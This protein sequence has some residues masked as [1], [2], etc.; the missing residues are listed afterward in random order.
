MSINSGMDK[1]VVIYIHIHICVCVCVCVC[2]CN[3]I[4]L[5]I[6]KNEII[7]F[8][9]IWMDL[10]IVILSEVKS[11]RKRQI[12]YDLT[13]MWNLEKDYKWT[14]LQNRNWVS[15]IENKLIAI[16]GQGRRDK[17]EGWDGHAHITIYKI[18]H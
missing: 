8:V 14:Y 7:P 17:L 10:E 1:G 2:V 6:K 12:S 11:D 16:G 4:L 15:E 9:A 18:D 5:A 3:G 13:Y